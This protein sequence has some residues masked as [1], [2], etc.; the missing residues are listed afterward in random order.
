MKENGAWSVIWSC[1]FKEIDKSWNWWIILYFEQHNLANHKNHKKLYIKYIQ[2]NRSHNRLITY[3]RLSLIILLLNLLAILWSTWKLC[4]KSSTSDGWGERRFDK[5]IR[6][7]I[8][9]IKLFHVCFKGKTKF[10][11]AKFWCWNFLISTSGS[12][13]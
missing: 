7:A 8:L 9:Q 3:L 1:L 13:P 11:K 6:D 5:K 4:R 2:D 10:K 12:N